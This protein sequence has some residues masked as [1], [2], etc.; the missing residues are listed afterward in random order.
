MNIKLNSV[1]SN[2]KAGTG[3]IR[4]EGLDATVSIPAEYGGAGTDSNPKELFVASTVAC[5]IST[6]TAMIAGKKL[7]I[8]SLSVDTKANADDED[9][10]IVHVAHVKLPEG[11][12]QSDI[13]KAEG[14]VSK[15]DEICIV[16]NLAR[17]AGVTINAEADVSVA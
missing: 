7:E 16:G 6:L 5:F 14:L 15:A 4:S 11:A 3:N 2:G 8:V 12:S 10:S 17:E 13:E 1:W 9:F